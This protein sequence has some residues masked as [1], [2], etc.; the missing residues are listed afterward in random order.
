MIRSAMVGSWGYPGDQ[1]SWVVPKDAEVG[2]R[3]DLV[4]GLMMSD[5]SSGKVIAVLF[6]CKTTC[7]LVG[8][9]DGCEAGTSVAIFQSRFLGCVDGMPE[10]DV[11]DCSVLKHRTFSADKF[12]RVSE[13]CC[14]AGCLTS[15]LQYVGFRAVTANGWNPVLGDLYSCSHLYADMVVG[16]IAHQ[17]TICELHVAGSDSAVFCAGFSCQPF[18]RGGEQGGFH[19]SMMSFVLEF[20]SVSPS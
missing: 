1:V 12:W 6:P 19:V 8:S 10:Y 20:S 4:A 15:G 17:Q 13:T 16:D 2:T 9:L 3:H 11:A 5:P 7:R 14:G 18:S